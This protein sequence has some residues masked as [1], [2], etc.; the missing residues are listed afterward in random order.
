MDAI[1][2]IVLS[3]VSLSIG[4]LLKVMTYEGKKM[5]LAE[6]IKEHR[7]E[8]DDCI[9][10]VTYR[11]DGNGGRGKIPVPPPTHNDEERRQWILNDEGLYRWARS[12]GA[13]I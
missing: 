13:K 1:V 2:V 11:Y 8:I 5:K 12:E 10:R 4:S 7:Q 9:N 3:I 6:F